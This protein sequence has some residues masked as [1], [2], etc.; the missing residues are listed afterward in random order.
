AGSPYYF[1]LIR[2]QRCRW[3]DYDKHTKTLLVAYKDGLVKIQDKQ[4]IPILYNGAPVSVITML[5]VGDKYYISTFEQG[6]L[7]L[8][9]SGIKKMTI[10]D[11]YSAGRVNKIKAFSD[12]V[13]LLGPGFVVLFNAKTEKLF[14]DIIIPDF[15]NATIYDVSCEN[16][17]LLLLT[18]A[19][20]FTLLSA[21][22]APATSLKNYL[23]KV[24][25]NGK[26]TVTNGNLV[27][28]HDQNSLEFSLSAPFYTNTDKIYFKYRLEGSADE[29]WKTSP[30]GTNVFP[31]LSLSPGKYVFEAMAVHSQF[32]IAE[33]HI[34]FP[35]TIRQAWYNTLLFRAL[36]AIFVT[37]FIVT[38]VIG[39]YKFRLKQQSLAFQQQLAVS[40]ERQRISAEIHDDI[41]AGLSGVRLLTELIG[42]KTDDNEIKE[43]LGKIY[44]SITEL[45][46]KMQEVIWS[47]NTS[48]DT[49]E[50]LLHYLKKQAIQLFEYSTVELV[51]NLPHQVPATELESDKRADIYLA[52]KE[53]LHNVLKHSGAGKAQLDCSITGNRLLITVTDNGK[54]LQVPAGRFG[55]N[56][57]LNMKKRIAR[58]KG[59]IDINSR[60]GV[61]V[62]FDIP[63]KI[64]A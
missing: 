29:E 32:G 37:G 5:L 11:K 21:Q 22:P 61:K 2:D 45:S 58:L 8:D 36:L 44:S 27:L 55:G 10:L 7:R 30:A 51:V 40:N 64:S 25:V 24:A 56:G 47:L 23:L 34:V 1:K 4:V 28:L 19:G 31:F 49:L 48:N 62:Q 16:N 59:R 18:S 14:K 54:G 20:I 3:V 42:N 17:Q 12:T 41:G 46:A 9:A 35:F 63:I 26:D 6:M 52:V 13:V 38:V 53:A 50:N 39:F 15:P 60:D 57:M 33:K 43:G